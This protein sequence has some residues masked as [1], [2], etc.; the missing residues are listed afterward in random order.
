M[1]DPSTTTLDMV[2]LKAAGCWLVGGGLQSTPTRCSL[3]SVRREAGVLYQGSPTQLGRRLGPRGAET[4]G[5]S[6][7][8]VGR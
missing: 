7:A 2:L 3:G 1:P 4:A 6:A 8:A 5:L